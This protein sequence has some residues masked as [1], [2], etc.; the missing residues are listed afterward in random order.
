MPYDPS[1][2]QNWLSTIYGG[3]AQS[4][5]VSNIGSSFMMS[6][7]QFSGSTLDPIRPSNEPMFEMP[8]S[9]L[10]P[11]RP[12]GLEPNYDIEMLPLGDRMAPLMG[13]VDLGDTSLPDN[14]QV[15]FDALTAML[16]ISLPGLPS[17]DAYGNYGITPEQNEHAGKQA[18]MS[19]LGDAGS[20]FLGGSPMIGTQT[21]QKASG[22]YDA[23][24][25]KASAL[26]VADYKLKLEAAQNEIDRIAKL[27]DVERQQLLI[28]NA[29]IDLQSKKDVME[30]AKVWTEKMESVALPYLD[31]A[32]FEDEQLKAQG[33]MPYKYDALLGGLRTAKALAIKGDLAGSDLAF[34]QAISGLSAV[35]QAKF[36]MTLANRTFKESENFEA[37]FG[38]LG[39]YREMAKKFG[40]DIETDAQGNFVW[41]DPYDKQMR[42]A[43]LQQA[44]A[45]AQ[46]DMARAEAAT[47][48]GGGKP[49]T[50]QQLQQGVGRVMEAATFISTYKP[51]SLGMLP[52]DKRTAIQKQYSD[53]QAALLEFNINPTP[54]NVQAIISNPQNAQQAV[55]NTM[56]QNMNL[57]RG[58]MG[59]PMLGGQGAPG[60]PQNGALPPAVARLRELQM[61]S[62]AARAILERLHQEELAGGRKRT[63]EELLQVVEQLT[64][65]GGQ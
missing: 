22:I 25:G 53:A 47:M 16:G 17:R 7:H 39:H 44:R 21:G 56:I 64:S 41:L 38:T 8:G 62:P 37:T 59:G 29:K 34:D 31:K 9:T 61:Q 27:S 23:A 26:N 60:G 12:G 48:F 43:A 5:P 36:K 46:L 63:P 15:P 40:I 20:M 2:F 51:E 35:E 49:P 6:P 42:D 52:T 50:S 54:E 13:Q 11:I 24:L 4:N 55:T 65:G 33:L 18:F 57:M 58:W 3:G 1:Q 30:I 32:K 28:D 10:D 19:V 45:G 14:N